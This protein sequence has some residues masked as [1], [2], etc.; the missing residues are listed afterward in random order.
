M[1]SYPEALCNLAGRS[2]CPWGRENM[3]RSAANA[4]CRWLWALRCLLL[5]AHLVPA[6]AVLRMMMFRE[7][8]RWA[9]LLTTG[10][11]LTDRANLMSLPRLT[12]LLRLS[13]FCMSLSSRLMLVRKQGLGTCPLL[14]SLPVWSRWI[15]C[16][17][18]APRG[19][20]ASWAILHLVACRWPLRRLRLLPDGLEVK[21]LLAPD[22]LVS[23][24][25]SAYGLTG[26][27]AW[28]FRMGVAVWTV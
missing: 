9:S 20:H 28:M 6:W 2:A 26:R 14:Q 8:R 3:G 23:Y 17:V 12:V 5:V 10:P 4:R 7:C 22:L 13:R 19:L 18:Q 21:L 11:R 27:P 15:R 16:P 1:H 25:L 24:V